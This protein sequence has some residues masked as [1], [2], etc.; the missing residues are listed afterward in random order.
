MLFSRS[1][2]ST[3]INDQTSYKDRVSMFLFLIKLEPLAGGLLGSK[4]GYLA[5]M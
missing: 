5:I 4:P 3:S 2:L 1:Q